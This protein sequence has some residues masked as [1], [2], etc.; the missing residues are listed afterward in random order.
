MTGYTVHTGSIGQILD[1]LGQ[2]LQRS[3]GAKIE[4]GEEKAG[5]GS[6]RKKRKKEERP[7]TLVRDRALR[8]FS[9]RPF[10]HLQVAIRTCDPF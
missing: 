2:H 8:G 7:R 5:K 6:C 4:R 3:R 10:E 1:R 9:P